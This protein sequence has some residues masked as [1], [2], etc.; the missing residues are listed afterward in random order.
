MKTLRRRSFI[1]LIVLL[2]NLSAVPTWAHRS[3]MIKPEPAPPYVQKTWDDQQSIM[4]VEKLL[5]QSG[6]KYESG[7]SGVWKIRW[8]GRNFKFY[9]V[10]FTIRG[11]LFTDVIVATGRS[12]RVNEAAPVLLRLENGLDYVKI[13]LHPGDD[14]FVRSETRLK[15]LDVEEFKLNLQ[16]V[17]SAADSIY[18]EVQKFR[19]F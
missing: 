1:L 12:L 19:N 13:G 18:A 15:S 11:I 9:L 10:L 3:S 2:M 17:A 4:I 5:A 7:G 8:V 14:L 16:R 6:Q